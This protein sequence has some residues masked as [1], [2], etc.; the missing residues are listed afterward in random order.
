MEETQSF[1]S[2]RKAD[3]LEIPVSYIGGHNIVYWDD[4]EQVFPGVQ[5]VQNGKVV[6]NILK[7]SDGNR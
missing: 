4:I 1:R 6:V 3:I 5:H 2:S 7:D